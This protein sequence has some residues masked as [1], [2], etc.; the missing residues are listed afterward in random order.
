MH[1]AQIIYLFNCI[2][3]RE[4]AVRESTITGMQICAFLRVVIGIDSEVALSLQYGVLE[5]KHQLKSCKI[6]LK[7][8][9]YPLRST[10]MAWWQ[11]RSWYCII[12]GVWIWGREVV[13]FCNPPPYHDHIWFHTPSPTAVT[14]ALAQ[15][16]ANV[17]PFINSNYF[18]R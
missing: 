15:P 16:M 8:D 3:V 11:I 12:S 17:L 9:P 1:L 2:A 13:R 4:S 14:T 10:Q 5:H 7:N 6:P 18:T